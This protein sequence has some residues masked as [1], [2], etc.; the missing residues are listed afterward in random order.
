MP[1][2]ETFSS[3]LEARIRIRKDAP[4]KRG[5]VVYWMWRDQRVDDNWAVVLLHELAERLQSGAAIFVALPE[6]YLESS[7][8]QY[9]FMLDGL[10]EVENDCASCGISFH[11]EVG[12]PGVAIPAFLKKSHATALITDFCPLHP[13]EKWKRDVERK[14]TL[15][16]YEVD[17]HN[18]VPCWEASEKMEIGARTLRPKIQKQLETYLTPFPK[19][20]KVN[21][22]FPTKQL[23]N[24]PSIE[25][26]IKAP[27]VPF[28]KLF[29][30]G[31]KAAK[32]RLDLFL[33]KHFR[34]YDSNRNDPTLDHQS[35]LSPYLHF[36]Q[37]APQRVAYEASRAKAPA[38]DKDAFFD[39]LIIR[40]ELSDNFCF[41][42]PNY[43]NIKCFP[44]WATTSL[45]HHIKDTRE[46]IYSLDIFEDG[47]THDPLWNAAQ[48]EMVHTGKMPGFLR[49]YWAKKVLEWTKT[50]EEAFK[51]AIYL[52]N[53]YELDGCD[54]NGYAGVAWSIG[55]VHDRAWPERKIF[56]K[57]RYMNFSGCKRKFS[58]SDYISQIEKSLL[59]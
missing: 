38:P 7:Y 1:L 54:P 40:R 15:P 29:V 8:R 57:V 44:S 51:I 50:P 39:E 28:S 25:K 9:K 33:D 18:I 6:T 49:M 3:E 56:G 37:I 13:V 34:G 30:P 36:G 12:D 11:L 59:A 10:K 41:Y 45:K 16:I 35:N 48:N 23:L 2:D 26:Q 21:N 5:P 32:K 52:N 58:V 14:T 46:Y 53:K 4:L 47:K 19:L 22:S 27:K 55:G 24:W 31:K 42:N 43:D 20:K 17:A